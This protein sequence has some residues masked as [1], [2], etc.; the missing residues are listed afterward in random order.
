MTCSFENRRSRAGTAILWTI[1]GV[2]YSN[3]LQRRLFFTASI[4]FI[5]SFLRAWKAS[6]EEEFP[7][8]GPLLPL[9]HGESLPLPPLL[10]ISLPYFGAG[11]ALLITYSAPSNK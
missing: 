4:F 3:E 2:R 10:A 1:G 11:V 9:S 6:R 7:L 5:F 8:A